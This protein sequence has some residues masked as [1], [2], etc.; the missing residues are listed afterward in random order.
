MCILCCFIV[1][2]SNSE[3]YPAVRHYSKGEKRK[4]DS[5]EADMVSSISPDT[6][7]DFRETL[8]CMLIKVN[9]PELFGSILISNFSFV[10]FK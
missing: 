10:Y 5:E 8:H 7:M 9:E 2:Q 4:S 6:S 3:G 1:L